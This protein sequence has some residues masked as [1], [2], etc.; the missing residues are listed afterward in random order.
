MRELTSGWKKGQNNLHIC[1]QTHTVINMAAAGG[2]IESIIWSLEGVRV[3]SGLN[4]KYFIGSHVCIPGLWLTVLFERLIE[5]LRFVASLA[6]R[7]SLMEVGFQSLELWPTLSSISIF[8]F[9]F[10]TEDVI[11]QVPA[12]ATYCH[13]SRISMNSPSGTVDPNKLSCL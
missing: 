2:N 9:L 8:C 5:C 1:F 11:S 10:V 12:L 4:K 6:E 13:A 7:S 3:C